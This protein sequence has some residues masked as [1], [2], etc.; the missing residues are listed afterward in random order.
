MPASSSPASFR[1]PSLV[2]ARGGRRRRSVRGRRRDAAR[3]AASRASPTRTRSSCLLTDAIDRDGRSTRRP[4]LK[5][6]ANVAVGYNNIDVAYARSR[7]VVV[8]NTPDVLTESVA[9]FTWALILAITRRL[10]EGERLVRRG[11]WKGWAFD[12]MLGTE[13]RG[14][15]LGL[16]GVGRIGRAV[17]ARAPAFGMRVAYTQAPRRRRAGGAEAMSL[18]RLLNTSDIV[19]LHVPLTPETRHL[20]DKRALARMKR[21]AYLDQHGAR[22]GR[23][24][25]GAGLGASAAPDRRRGARRLRERAGGASRSAARSRTCCSCRTSAA[26]RPRRGTAMADLA[27]DNVVAVLSGRPPLTP[28]RMKRA[29][30]AERRARSQSTGPP[31]AVD[32]VMR[33]LARA[34]DGLELPAVEKI[35]ETQEEDPFQVLIAHAAVGADAGRDDAGG[36]DAAVQGG[37]RR[38]GRWRADRQADRAAD[39]PGQL[40]SPQGAA[41][42]G[43]LPDPRRAFGGRVPTTMEELLTLPGVGRKTANLVLILAFKSRAEHLRRHARAPHLES[44]RLG[45]HADARRDRAGA[46]RSDRASAGGRTST[47]TS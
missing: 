29:A 15:Q 1:R 25:G 47:C 8:T 35:S 36:V 37:A 16:V 42:E 38:R 46:L 22:P 12:F 44:A 43:D 2:Q 17:A 23:R 39:L 11:G 19:S 7:G 6:V 20:I 45:A 28:V 24:R 40:L 32:A 21:S 27:V 14:K 18:D 3:R 9:D 4:A 41:R 13:L 26:G 31:S 5:V 10:S 34:I 33:A 30:S